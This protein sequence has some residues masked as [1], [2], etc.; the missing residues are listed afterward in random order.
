ML[1]L[2][3]GREAYVLCQLATEWNSAREWNSV[4]DWKP[5]LH[6]QPGSYATHS[7]AE[8]RMHDVHLL[9]SDGGAVSDPP[10]FIAG[11]TRGQLELLRVNLG[12]WGLRRAG[13]IAHPSQRWG[14]ADRRHASRRQLAGY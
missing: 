9:P 10:F 6:Y 3:S 1:A 8:Q 11:Q 13:V 2:Y 7:E 12:G 5:E 4:R 14:K